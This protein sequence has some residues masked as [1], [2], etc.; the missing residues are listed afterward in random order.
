VLTVRRWW[1]PVV[2]VAVAL[3]TQVIPLRATWLR[4]LAVL[5]LET[6]W[7]A[8]RAEIF[9]P[10]CHASG[11][12]P[13]TKRYLELGLAQEPANVRTLTHLGRV[14][15][16][17][18]DCEEALVQWS[19]AAASG[20]LSAA[21]ELFRVG[22][23]S[24]LPQ[25]MRRQL[26]DMAYK[27]AL[28]L[29]IAA[30]DQLAHQWVSRAIALVPQHKNVLALEGW[31][32]RSGDIAA[33]KALWRA[34]ANANSTNDA[35]YWFATARIHEQDSQWELAAIAYIQGAGL[36]P[37][38]REFWLQAGHAWEQISEW[39]RAIRAYEQALAIRP[40]SM[41]AYISLAN[42]YRIRG[43]YPEAIGF[44]RL[45][46][47]VEPDN[48][49]PYY[50]L[51]LVFSASGDH[52]QARLNFERALDLSPDDPWVMYQ[53]ARLWYYG[54][55]Q[56]ATAESW[57]VRAISHLEQPPPVWWIELGDWRLA[58]RRC[59]DASQ[60]YSAARDAGANEEMIEP[61]LTQ[62]TSLC[63]SN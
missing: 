4:N 30:K 44:L 23:Y 49:L 6:P 34:M 45:A 31:Y 37:D 57:L 14:R 42:V 1:L 27:Y 61:K 5:E 3:L 12:F 15:W 21:Y 26:A 19:S 10:P 40:P 36:S 2:A 51:G 50:Y 25:E 39:D 55:S 20:D 13:G 29:A 18:G 43:Q 59:K 33:I 62:Y 52:A 11:T 60:A 9:D 54:I 63:G 53:L 48:F 32:G 35:E 17:E 46:Q 38:P 28:E 41:F 56:P 58:Q 7:L 47:E 8:Q 22:R 24:E 16:L